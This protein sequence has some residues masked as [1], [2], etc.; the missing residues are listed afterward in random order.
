MD[1]RR[2]TC[3]TLPVKIDMIQHKHAND[4]HNAMPTTKGFV[5]LYSSPK[6]FNFLMSLRINSVNRYNF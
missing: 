6:D 3:D 2:S 4:R 5:D 1:Q